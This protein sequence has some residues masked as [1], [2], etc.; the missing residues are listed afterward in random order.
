MTLVGL[1]VALGPLLRVLHFLLPTWMLLDIIYLYAGTLSV[2]VFFMWGAFKS[3]LKT[4]FC[5]LF[6]GWRCKPREFTLEQYQYY[7]AARILNKMGIT[8][9]VKIFVTDNP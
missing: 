7:D 8:K 4:L 6:L 2:T 3:S 1:S 9:S 5:S